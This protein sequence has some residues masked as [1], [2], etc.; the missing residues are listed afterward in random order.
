MYSN[1]M[2][3]GELPNGTDC[4]ILLDSGATKSFMSKQ[5]YL[6]NKCLYSL[7]RF[8]SET[9]CIQVGNGQFVNMLFIIPVIIN[10]H[11][12]LFEIYTAVA[13]IHNNVDWVFWFKEYV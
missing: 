2:T 1:G 8:I 9:K 10:L 12:L 3:V 4:H 7:A 6:N 11:G 13:E 5:Y